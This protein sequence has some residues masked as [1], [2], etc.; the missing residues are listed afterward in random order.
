MAG[1]EAEES[2]Y[3]HYKK[4]K[5]FFSRLLDGGV[6]LYNSRVLLQ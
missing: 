2:P 3:F 5:I 6:L 4:G 1:G